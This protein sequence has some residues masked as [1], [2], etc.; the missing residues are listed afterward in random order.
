MKKLRGRQTGHKHSEETKLKIGAALTQKIYFNCDYCG[1]RSCDKPSSY[2]RNKH[3][4][5]DRSC[6]SSDRK[7][8]KREDQ[9]A[10]KNGGMG[11]LE[12]SRRR[13]CRSDANHAIYQG[14]L[15]RSPCEE[16]GMEIAEAHHDDYSKP[17]TVR[18]LCFK[19]HREFHHES[20]DLIK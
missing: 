8:W 17:L 10:Y 11:E 5:C 19:H 12:R 9:Q 16:C 4:Y 6:Y 1:G 20:P 3:H 18:W 7:S 15:L 13:K 2:N 14:K